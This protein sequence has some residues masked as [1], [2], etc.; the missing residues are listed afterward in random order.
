MSYD[1]AGCKRSPEGLFGFGALGKIEFLSSVSHHQS[2]GASLWSA[3]MKHQSA[4]PLEILKKS[5]LILRSPRELSACGRHVMSSSLVL[6][7]TC[8]VEEPM[9]LNMPR[10]KVFS[11]VWCGC[12]E[13]ELNEGLLSYSQ[14]SF[15]LL[16]EIGLR[17]RVLKFLALPRAFLRAHPLLAPDCGNPA[18]LEP[19]H[20]PRLN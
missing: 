10:L 11:L 18:V 13:K 16:I 1:Y 6:L 3:M 14:P 9:T 12:S 17:S 8:R 2:S 7:K 5:R 15:N 4:A 20:F 19:H